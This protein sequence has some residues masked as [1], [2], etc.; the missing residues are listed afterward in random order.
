MQTMKSSTFFADEVAVHEDT[1][2][3]G[4]PTPQALAFEAKVIYSIEDLHPNPTK[5]DIRG[6]P[7]T[8]EGVTS[9]TT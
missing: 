7:S 4:N 9:I 5:T 3:L 2:N 6:S 1:R 8:T